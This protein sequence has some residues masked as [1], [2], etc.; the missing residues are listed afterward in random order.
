MRL[1]TT[2]NPTTDHKTFNWSCTGP[3]EESLENRCVALELE[4]TGFSRQKAVMLEKVTVTLPG[5]ASTHNTPSAD[6]AV[7]FVAS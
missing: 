1:F 7:H 3:T 5:A 2:T 6:S 4:A